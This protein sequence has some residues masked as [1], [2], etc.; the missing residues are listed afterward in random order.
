[1]L[2][3]ELVQQLRESVLD[4]T[5]EPYLWSTP[6]LLRSLNYA[7]RQ[8]CR[9]AQLIIDSV[10]AN[11]YGTAA[12]AGTLGQKPLCSLSIVADQATYN[13]SPKVLQIKRCQLGTMAY[14]LRGPVEYPELDD[15]MSG[16]F[17]T[18]G[19]IGT[20]GSGGYPYAFANQPNDTITFVLA[21]SVA[22]TA[23]L[24]VSRLPLISFTLQTQPE[25]PEMYHEGLLDWA[26]HLA[27]M[28]PDSDTLNLELAAFYEAKFTRQ[29][30]PLPDA[31]SEKMRKTLL[32][33][34]RMRPRVFG[35]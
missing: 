30:G 31:Y 16:W 29:F 18:N 19:T 35:S 3:S 7:E 24:V 11:D 2:G 13:L 4:D 33:Q 20:A 26:A 8:A 5:V 28:K 22:D 21:P 17:G 6:E 34:Q 14:P 10:T 23:R 25:I 9:R 32:Q 12:T 27:Y 15:T 1:M